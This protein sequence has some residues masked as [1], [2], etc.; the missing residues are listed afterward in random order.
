MSKMKVSVTQIVE[1]IESLS[2]VELMELQSTLQGRWKVS[3]DQLGGASAA[4]QAPSVVEDEGEISYNLIATGMKDPG[5]K[6]RCTIFLKNDL[7]VPMQRCRE[8]LESLNSKP[9]VELNIE[10][11]RADRLIKQAAAEEI[12][13]VLERV[14]A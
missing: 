3:E 5:K 1:D 13:L 8:I 12:G 6:I 2:L 7:Q 11:E 10:K 14:K 9:V 4:Q